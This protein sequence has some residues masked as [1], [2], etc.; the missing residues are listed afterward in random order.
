MREFRYMADVYEGNTP[1][2]IAQYF[3]KGRSIIALKATEGQ[4]H[5]DV[6]H[7]RRSRESHAAGGTVMH[8]HY[9]RPDLGNSPTLEADLFIKAVRPVWVP[10]D[11]LMC[12]IESNK[13]P[14]EVGD[15]PWLEKFAERC[16]STF[17]A[18]PVTY[19]NQSTFQ[20]PLRK[21]RIP[22]RRCMV[23]LW[24]PGNP[25]L[26]P[27]LREWAKQF[28]DGAVGPQPHTAP[29]I[30]RCDQSELPLWV[31]LPLWARTRRRRGVFSRKAR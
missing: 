4:T 18:T 9:A 20:G 12:D 23:A 8:Y 17:G 14:V 25:T 30:G 19:A 5:V 16:H 29:G 28:T 22:G 13:R 2:D 10:G 3:Y 1:I 31:A 24:G 26:P 27:G 15:V 6:R 7:A 21:L 11:Y